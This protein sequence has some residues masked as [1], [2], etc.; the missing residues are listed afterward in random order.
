VAKVLAETTGAEVTLLHVVDDP[1]ERG[2]GE[3]F[4]ASW[5]DEHGLGDAELVVDDGGDV[6]DGICRAADGKTLVIIGATEKGLLSRLV[7]NSLH[8]DVIHDVDASV[9]LTERP[10]S[11]SL[12]ERLFG[13]GRRATDLS[14]GV[15]R[16]PER[17]E[18]TDVRSP[19]DGGDED[20]GGDRDDGDNGGDGN[21]GSEPDS[22]DADAERSDA[23]EA[24]DDA[25]ESGGDGSGDRPDD[26]AADDAPVDEQ[27]H[28]DD[29]FVA[30]HDAADEEAAEE[31]D[32]EE[33]AAERDDEG[34]DDR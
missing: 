18:G 34:D 5:A 33:A 30:D 11:R 23:T 31:A 1:S 20:E 12:R 19:D 7:S 6:E 29:T 8:L 24:T 14:R 21:H 32:A 3:A 27:P 26:A 28:L 2:R 25:A 22:A 13:S 9:L 17:S 16:D 4:L 10:S 15:E